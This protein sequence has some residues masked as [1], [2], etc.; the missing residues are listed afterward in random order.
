MELVVSSLFRALNDDL[1]KIANSQMNAKI[2]LRGIFPSSFSSLALTLKKLA[3]VDSG[4]YQ[5]STRGSSD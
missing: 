5:L 1:M 2:M 4:S 3:I